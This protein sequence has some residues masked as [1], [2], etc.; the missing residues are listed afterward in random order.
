MHWALAGSH[1]VRNDSEKN[2]SPTL[3]MIPM[4]GGG[5]RIR[6]SE[7]FSRQIYSLFPL[8]TREPHH[9]RLLE[10]AEGLEPTTH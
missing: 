1:V 9:M 5:G 6:T 8:A 10:P 4:S 3:S 7:G 2:G